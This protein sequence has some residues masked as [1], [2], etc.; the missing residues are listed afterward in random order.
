MAKLVLLIAGCFIITGC[1]KEKDFDFKKVA[2]TEWR[3]DLAAPL[4]NSDLTVKDLIGIAD[5]G[6]FSTDQNHF[7]TLVYRSSLYSA[8]LPDVAPIPDQHYDETIQ[9]NSN[10]STT[11]RTTNVDKIINNTLP[12]TLP[13]NSF[14]TSILLRTAFLKISLAS[15][16]P[17]NGSVN[18]SIPSLELNGNPFSKDVSFST[19]SGNPIQLVDSFSL[20]GYTI[21]FNSGNQFGIIYT[22]HFNSPGVMPSQITNL[23]FNI[24]TGFDAVTPGAVYGNLGSQALL[25]DQDTSYISFFNNFQNGSIYFTDPKISLYISNSFGLPV[26]VAITSI[27]A[28]NKTGNSVVLTGYPSTIQIPYPTVA[29]QIS[30]DSIVLTS[31]NSNVRDAMAINPVYLVYTATATTANAPSQGF[32]LDTSQFNATVRIDLPLRGYADNFTLQDTADFQL[33]RVQEIE[34]ADFLIHIKNGFPGTAI[35]QIYFADENYVILDSMFVN[36][37][38]KTIQ[39]AQIDANGLV[40]A[41]SVNVINIPFSGTRIE[42]LY[43]SRKLLLNSRMETTNAPNRIVEIYD[44][45][46]MNVKIGVRA[47]VKMKLQ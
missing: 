47:Q 11:L 2:E 19:A 14:L 10:D 35:N 17:L 40:I 32:V 12:F 20:A 37:A 22:V 34:S 41:P 38:D 25:I 1:L 8:S 3:P 4:V 46:K 9:L 21:N 39:G 26:N 31:S 16:I 43:N 15:Y 27:V 7:V 28:Y 33:D 30:T 42:H 23:D 18:V 24:T 45:Y 13:A 6:T 36:N 5:S 29:G 44:F